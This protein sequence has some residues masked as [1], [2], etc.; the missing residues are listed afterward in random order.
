M[1]ADPR[2]QFLAECTKAQPKPMLHEI[3]D[4][5]VIGVVPNREVDIVAIRIALDDH[6]IAV[7]VP[8]VR[9]PTPALLAVEDV[10]LGGG[11]GAQIDGI[12]N[13]SNSGSNIWIL[14]SYRPTRQTTAL[15]P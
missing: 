6:L 11:I 14:F 8:Y 15:G 7:L 3:D 10:A 4:G 1:S 9:R 5:T 13:A 2:Q 12:L